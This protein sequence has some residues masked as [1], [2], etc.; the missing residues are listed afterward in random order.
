MDPR[1]G[2]AT[3][4]RLSGRAKKTGLAPPTHPPCLNRHP[5]LDHDPQKAL[6]HPYTFSCSDK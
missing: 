6:Y 4:R 3:V 5:L 2:I 1:V